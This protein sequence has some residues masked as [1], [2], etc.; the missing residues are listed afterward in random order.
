MRNKLLTG[1]WDAA[2]AKVRRARAKETKSG[3]RGGCKILLY[4]HYAMYVRI[5]T[6]DNV[7]R[8]EAES[9]MTCFK[10]SGGS[11]DKQRPRK[12]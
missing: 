1:F 3:L 9:R 12:K 8:T 10:G 7:A 6:F 11:Y 5:G 4:I 2:V